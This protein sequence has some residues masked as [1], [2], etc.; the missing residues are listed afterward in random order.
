MDAARKR[1]SG[2]LIFALFRV[3]RTKSAPGLVR[4]SGFNRS[5]Y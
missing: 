5:K 4:H 1:S 3:D 2:R